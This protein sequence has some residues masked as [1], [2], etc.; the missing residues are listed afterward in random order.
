MIKTPGAHI[1]TSLTSFGIGCCPNCAP[2]GAGLDKR[3]VLR[4]PKSCRRRGPTRLAIPEQQSRWDHDCLHTQ[5][6]RDSHTMMP[7]ATYA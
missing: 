6:R 5:V 1:T 7:E 3:Q 2:S 4:N